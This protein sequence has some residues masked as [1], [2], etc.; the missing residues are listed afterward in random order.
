MRTTLYDL[1]ARSLGI[2]EVAGGEH[3]PLIQFGFALC[4]GYGLE[5]PDEVPWCS[6]WLQ[7][8]PWL[9]GLPH[10]KSAAAR[11][12]LTVGTPIDLDDARRG[13]DVVILSRAGSPT[14]GHVGLYV[15]H[16]AATATVTLLAGNQGNR[17]SVATFPR[18]RILGVRRLYEEVTDD[19]P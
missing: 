18:D 2:R 8:W 4:S 16:D 6:A 14:A 5:T 10:S 9:L 12:W 19:T 11:S 17:V 1:A 13:F 3:H 7:V 15:E